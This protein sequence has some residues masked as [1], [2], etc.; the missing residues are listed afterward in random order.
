VSRVGDEGSEAIGVVRGRPHELSADVDLPDVKEVIGQGSITIPP[1]YAG[2]DRSPNERNKEE[3]EKDRDT[4][5]NC[6]Q[7]PSLHTWEAVPALFT[8]SVRFGA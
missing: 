1:G 8:A 4:H 6:E 5:P 2:N 3:E 7:R